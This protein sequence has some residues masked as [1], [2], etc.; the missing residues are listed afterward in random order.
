MNIDLIEKGL[1]L[2]FNLYSPAP[3]I[4]CMNIDL[5]EK[6]RQNTLGII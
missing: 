4:E 2:V 3:D 5:I 6:G 1:R